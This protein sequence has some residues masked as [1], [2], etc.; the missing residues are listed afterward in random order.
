LRK[1][2]ILRHWRQ[3]LNKRL[4]DSQCNRSVGASRLLKRRTELGDELRLARTEI[5]FELQGSLVMC[6]PYQKVIPA[7]AKAHSCESS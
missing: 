4:S 2:L 1:T 6:D 7:L 3:A 5:R